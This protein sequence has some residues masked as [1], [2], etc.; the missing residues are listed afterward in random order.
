MVHSFHILKQQI[1]NF[2]HFN[3]ISHCSC[4]GIARITNQ[5][6]SLLLNY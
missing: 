2:K 5:D 6:T 4:P 3:V 1:Q